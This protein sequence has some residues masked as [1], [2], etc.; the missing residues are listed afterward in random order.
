[1]IFQEGREEALQREMSIKTMLKAWFE[2]NRTDVQA[3]QF[4]YAEI[5]KY[6]VFEKKSGKWKRKQRGGDGVSVQDS[7]RYYLRILPT[8][9]TGATSF[10]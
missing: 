1:M 4:N 10:E 9:V 7:K 3:M 6:Y 5:P 2:S 8:R